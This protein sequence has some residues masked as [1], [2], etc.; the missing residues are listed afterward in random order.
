MATPDGRRS[1][2]HDPAALR[3]GRDVRPAGRA[4]CLCL[5]RRVSGLLLAVD[6]GNS[7]TDVALLR[8]DG[9]VLAAVRGPTVSHQAVGA[10]KGAARLR[11]LASVAVDAAGAAG[12]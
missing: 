12:V 5:I 3:C 7:K 1:P 6:G 2:G 4:S 10:E 11:A 9:T 8:A